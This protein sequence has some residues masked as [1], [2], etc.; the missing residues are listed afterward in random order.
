MNEWVNL[1]GSLVV[2]GT[3]VLVTWLVSRH[4]P[5]V[6]RRTADVAE[7]QLAVDSL[8]AASLEWREYGTIMAARAESAEKAAAAAALAAEECRDLARQANERAARAERYNSILLEHWPGGYSL[9]N[10]V[11]GVT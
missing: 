1:I 9:P 5:Q 2:T 7:N 11:K 8:K 10:D 4:K 6:D 3:A